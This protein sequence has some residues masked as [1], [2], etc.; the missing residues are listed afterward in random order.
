LPALAQKAPDREG[1]VLN[2]AIPKFDARADGLRGIASMNVVLAH[3]FTCFVPVILAKNYVRLYDGD[4]D[5][6]AIYEFLRFPLFNIFYNG[7]FA[8]LVFFVLSGYV[9]TL[10]AYTGNRVTIQR[11][12]WARYLRLNIPVAASV[13]LAW[14]LF[15]NGMFLIDGQ[16][17]LPNPDWTEYRFPDSI[18]AWQM[19]LEAVFTAVFMGDPSLNAPLWSIGTEFVGSML[20][21]AF[22]FP[23][24]R[25]K[26]ITV[27][28]VFVIGAAVYTTS[29][30]YLI[31]IF[32]GAHIV[33]LR[34][35]RA[36]V[37]LYGILGI[38]LGGY[39]QG[40][41]YY[42]YLNAEAWLPST[43]NMMNMMGAVCLT[44]AVINGF[45]SRLLLHPWAQFL[46]RVSFPLYIL[47]FILLVSFGFFTYDLLPHWAFVTGAHFALYV[48]VCLGLSLLFERWI[49]QPAIRLS[50]RF[51]HAVMGRL[52]RAPAASPLPDQSP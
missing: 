16:V 38:Y 36:G 13:F 43:K 5:A 12:F 32:A 8:V 23:P 31:A 34:P 44:T 35:G 19:L 27:G 14:L 22:Y 37:L 52:D 6:L 21:L 30:V 47:H 45:A 46:G 15:T 17:A 10:P 24:G 49:D 39:Q 2:K 18:P 9:L 28:A 4:A 50:K 51:A 41:I 48:A 40:S 29:A 7:Q 20:L 33:R 42:S 25:R 3:Y 11:R 1:D 26:W